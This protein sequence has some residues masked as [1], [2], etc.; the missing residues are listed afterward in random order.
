M[1]Q[2]TQDQSATPPAPHS[3]SAAFTPALFGKTDSAGAKQLSRDQQPGINPSRLDTPAETHTHLHSV[4]ATV[5][6]AMD[7]LCMSPDVPMPPAPDESETTPAN[8]ERPASTQLRFSNTTQGEVLYLGQKTGP[9]TIPILPGMEVT[10][11][12]PKTKQYDQDQQDQISAVMADTPNSKDHTVSTYRESRN[13]LSNRNTKTV[14]KLHRDPA[15]LASLLRDHR[16]TNG[17]C[18]SDEP[19]EVDGV[20]A[21]ITNNA[22]IKTPSEQTPVILAKMPSQAA[23]LPDAETAAG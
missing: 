1:H 15:M 23:Y 10:F 13:S 5:T 2:V 22:L 18:I 9:S 17:A 3:T 14:S 11:P 21:T 12:T 20:V 16:H 4:L 6:K 7:E 8:A 19:P